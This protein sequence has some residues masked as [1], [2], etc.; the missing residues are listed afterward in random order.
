MKKIFRTIMAVAIA[1]L[2][3]TACEDVPAPYENPNGQ[4]TKDPV[5]GEYINE[6]FV[7]N[8]GEFTVHTVTGTPWVIDFGTAKASGYDNSSQVTTPVGELPR[9]ACH[10][11]DVGKGRQR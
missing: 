7:S 2:T 5:E 9:V 4:G 3:F 10:R 1:A 6:T 8:F 11:L